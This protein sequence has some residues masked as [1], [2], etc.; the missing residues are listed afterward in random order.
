M[1]ARK[2]FTL[3]ELLVVIVI[4][5]ILAGAMLLS[6]G[7]TTAAADAS[8]IIT[9]LR[10]VKAAAGMY[11]A[12]Y[13]DT[14]A[15]LPAGDLDPT[16]WVKMQKYMDNPGKL[17]DYS[18][19]VHTDGTW[20]VTYAPSEGVPDMVAKMLVGKRTSMGLYGAVINKSATLTNKGDYVSGAVFMIAR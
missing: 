16:E 18:V 9:G 8:N 4:I 11:Y 5:G 13:M 12:D 19:H 20:W 6:S 3:V 17:V 14:A 15:S 1:K 7:S 2:G 10:S